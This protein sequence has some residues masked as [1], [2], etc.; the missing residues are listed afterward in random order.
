MILFHSTCISGEEFSVHESGSRAHRYRA[1]D[2][3]I[4]LCTPKSKTTALQLLL[5][6]FCLPDVV[7]EVSCNIF[8][9]LS[10]NC[11]HYAGVFE[12]V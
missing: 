5:T 2:V 3:L 12:V 11:Y 10:K 6:C 7:Y 9:T 1:T 8:E 4:S